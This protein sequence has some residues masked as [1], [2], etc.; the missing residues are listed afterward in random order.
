[1]KRYLKEKSYRCAI[2]AESVYKGRCLAASGLP[3]ANSAARHLF[4]QDYQKLFA[5]CPIGFRGMIYHDTH[6][7]SFIMAFRGSANPFDWITNAK[8]YFGTK[9]AHYEK[10]KEIIQ[11]YTGN[12]KLYLAGH[13][14]G[15]GLA[16]VA[17]IVSGLQAHVFN[18]PRI[19]EDTL[20]GFDIS[21]F[22]SRIHRY[23]MKG[24]Y[25]DFCST[26]N[27]P[28]RI[29]THEIG[30]KIELHVW[31]IKRPFLLLGGR[32]LPIIPE[33]IRLHGMKAVLKGLRRH[34]SW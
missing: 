32:V 24:E 27:K 3:L 15:G 17:S 12:E 23:V 20:D 30:E 34:F 10:A 6:D 21:A 33:A 28:F 7:D 16:T 5:V 25:L 19:H 4:G 9:A 31:C 22:H 29:W 2:V 14:L 1:M 8:Q 26:I 18:P 13:S 11:S